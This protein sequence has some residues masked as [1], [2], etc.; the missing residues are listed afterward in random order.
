MTYIEHQQQFLRM[1]Q[2]LN[3]QHALEYHIGQLLEITEES[4]EDL[5]WVDSR[6]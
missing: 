2:C 1:G 6:C 5:W 4:L 3:Y